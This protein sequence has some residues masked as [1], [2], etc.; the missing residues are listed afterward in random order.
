MTLTLP[1]LHLLQVPEVIQLGGYSWNSTYWYY[2]IIYNLIILYCN[3]WLIDYDIYQMYTKLFSHQN[4]SLIE[5][6]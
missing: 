5:S 3:Q 2:C 6:I 1:V 4:L